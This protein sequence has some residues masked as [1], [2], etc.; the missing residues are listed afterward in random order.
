MTK[1]ASPKILA[2]EG[3]RLDQYTRT[4]A[5]LYDALG[6]GYET[7]YA[8][9]FDQHTALAWLQTQLSPASRVLDI[10]CGTGKPVT[11]TLTGLGHAVTGLDV[12][13]EMVRLARLAA[14]SATIEQTD[15]RFYEAEAG[16]YDAVCAFFAL[17]H[18]PRSAIRATIE[19]VH[20]WLKPGGVFVLA[21]V[22]GDWEDATHQWMRRDVLETTMPMADYLSAIKESGFEIVRWSLA[23]HRVSEEEIEDHLFIHVRKKG[24]LQDSDANIV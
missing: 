23:P 18:M 22:P 17:F 12:S 21:T 15:V 24:S 14:P 9:L 8:N 1:Q 10:G 20:R 4:A 7:A 11:T 16:S 5:D 2:V 6:I 3:D 13:S 19:K